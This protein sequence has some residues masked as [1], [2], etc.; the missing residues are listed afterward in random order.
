MAHAQFSSIVSTPPGN[1]KTGDATV[2]SADTL[3][4]EPRYA[5]LMPWVLILLGVGLALY[6]GL[7]RTHLAS[8]SRTTEQ[9]PAQSA[10]PNQTQTLS[11]DKVTTTESSPSDALL[12]VLFGSAAVLILGGA[13]YSR[14]TKIT[15]PGGAGVEIAAVAQDLNKVQATVPAKVTRRIES[16]PEQAQQ[17]L[18]PAD[19][20]NIASL[21]FVSAQRQL[22]DLRAAARGAPVAPAVPL[23]MADVTRAQRGMPLSDEL[24]GQLVDKA[25]DE[26]LRT[27]SPPP[28][29]SANS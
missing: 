8:S 29:E 14:V 24:V 11:P 1:G 10:P 20:V 2:G 13:F 12:G 28:P 26:A 16:L 15:L 23:H 27:T 5:G 19:I 3:P 6:S 9:V 17:Q 25:V 21:A 22:L 18:Q 4:V 7:I